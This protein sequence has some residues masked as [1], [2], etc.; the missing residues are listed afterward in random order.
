L[1]QELSSILLIELPLGTSTPFLSSKKGRG[2]LLGRALINPQPNSNC[3]QLDEGE[4]ARI[5]SREDAAR[6]L[7]TAKALGVSFLALG[8][9]DYPRRL[10]MI[11][12]AP[13]AKLD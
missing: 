6:E 5:P 12:D 8:E 11:D 1:I 2:L 4:I 7:K 9:P 3:C 10:Q 13:R